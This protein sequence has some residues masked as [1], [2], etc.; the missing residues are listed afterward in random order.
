MPNQ[1]FQENSPYLLQHADNPVDWYPW[2]SDALEKAKAENKPIFLSIGYAA[3]HW[4]HVMAHESFEDP[5]TAAILN[6][7]FVNIK[8]DREERPDL[9]SIYMKAVVAMTGQG[10]WP[11]NVFLTPDLQ[12]FF[13]GTYFP[14]SR[15]YNLPAFQEVL[16]TI[17][18][19]WKQ[20]PQQLLS[21]A[22][23]ITSH[24]RSSQKLS[25]GDHRTETVL[26]E[27]AV[28]LLTQSYD[29][30][31][32][33]WGSAPKF[34]QPMTVEFLLRRATRGDTQARDMA[35]HVLHAMSKG[36][37]YDVV[38]GG[39]ARYST[40]NEWRVPHFEKMLSDN[41]QLALVYL[42][43]Y[44]ITGIENF[45]QTCEDTLDFVSREMTHP[46]GGFYSSLDADSE[47]IEGA[48]YIWS[49]EDIS[50]AL[51]APDD[52]ALAIAAYG[53]SAAG[54]FEGK[55]VLQRRL[56]DEQLAEHFSLPLREIPYRMKMIHHQLLFFRQT[57]VRPATDDK[58]IL[59]WNA[60]MLMAYAEAGRYLR[61]QDYTSVAMRNGRFLLDNL[62]LHNRLFRSWRNGQARH[63]AYLEDHASLILAFL[64]LYQSDPDPA[65]FLFAEHLSS[66][67]VINFQD[68]EGGFFDTRVDHPALLFR[69]K[70][71]QDNA[72]P[73]G[74]S[75]AALAFLHLSGFTGNTHWYDLAADSLN[76]TQ[77]IA[78]RYP[79]AFAQWL[80]ALDFSQGPNTE[81]AILYPPGENLSSSLVDHI[82]SQY[83]PRL[84]AAISHQPVPE[85]SPSLLLDRPIYN[86]LPTAYVCQRNTCSPPITKVEDLRQITL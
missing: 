37:M 85:G 29:W 75:L 39:F 38:G 22:S 23:Q 41:A 7:N 77:S 6:E 71:L 76:R 26:L 35:V 40:D 5:A 79:T 33:G 28:N 54:N 61:R 49:L 68:P 84:I 20:N 53:L 73:S 17:D 34:P 48:Y 72:T 74:N 83:R 55:N 4:C 51:I 78:I 32:G 8:V 57:K 43:A 24:I 1:L 70:D 3:C 60:L 10:G 82:W 19:L 46:L 62:L 12:P 80:S 86:N 66:E 16:L 13:G 63:D 44:L 58:I 65:W 42:H 69:P 47:G 59:F 18:R 31:H 67:L 15:R 27:D 25:G 56:N 64:S 21:S 30:Q 45:R 14:P 50:S 2:G 11:M 52:Q 36:G 81:V 9:D